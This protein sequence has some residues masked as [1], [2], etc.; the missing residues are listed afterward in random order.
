MADPG[1]YVLCLADSCTS[2]VHPVYNP[3]APHGYLPPNMY[4]FIADITS[5]DS[6]V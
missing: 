3:V 1:I 4:S 2:E 5:P 6:F